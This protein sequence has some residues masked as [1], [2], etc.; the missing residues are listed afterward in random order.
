[1][2]LILRFLGLRLHVSL[3]PVEYEATESIALTTTDHS[4]G[5]APTPEYYFTDDEDIDG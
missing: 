3:G 1:M 4:F 5:F 2:E